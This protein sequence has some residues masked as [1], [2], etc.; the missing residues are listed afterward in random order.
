MTTE[1][2]DSPPPHHY[3][4]I[5]PIVAMRRHLAMSVALLF[6]HANCS[7]FQ[8]PIT[9][10]TQP[11]QSSSITTL[12]SLPTS[13]KV[14]LHPQAPRNYQSFVDWANYYGVIEE[15]FSLQ[16]SSNNWGAAATQPANVGSRVLFV[17][18]MLRLTS[19]QLRQDEFAHVEPVIAQS[20]DGTTSN[21]EINLQNHF[22]LFLKILQEYDLGD[23]SPFHPW[24]D[25]M[26]RQF[27]TAIEFSD[28][29]MDCLPPFVKF[30]AQRDRHNYD[31]FTQVLQQLN[32][33]TIS[34]A[35]KQTPDITKWAF[36]VVFTR[37]RAM[38]GGT[39]EIIPMC[40]MLNHSAN[41]N[42]EVQYDNEGNV[43]VILLNSVQAGDG[44]HKCYGQ[45]TNPSRFLA[46]YGFFDV[47][48]PC[49]YCKLWPGL[50]VTNE[51]V[52][53]GF[54]FDRMVF[55][56]DNGEIANEVWDV[57]LYMILENIDRNMQ[58]QFYNAHM[59]GDEATKA[60]F[61]E[62][63]MPQTCNALL[64][65]VT[66]CLDE[67]ADCEKTIDGG[68]MG[69]VHEHLPIIRRH[70]DFVRQTFG[71]VRKVLEG[72]QASYS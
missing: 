58:Q 70:N 54:D 35:T 1:T 71:K 36:N 7:A 23:Q 66:E 72:I 43:H 53:L 5:N 12:C 10:Q 46:T 37:A 28:F 18:A 69:L 4:P 39:A 48:P 14:S 62:H 38:P 57:M 13:Q 40:D 19:E 49:T 27:N 26:P 63:Y 31:Q 21:G 50:I 68:G 29:E 44:L 30:L 24:L 15:N 59:S 9:Q 25:A 33:P 61:H 42:V 20:I 8:V 2:V 65:H 17:P 64:Q 22:L 34:D 16:P 6:A 45:P 56:V 52:N 55:Y 51:L 11:R 41:P 3:S 60:Q 47:S 67:I 32:T